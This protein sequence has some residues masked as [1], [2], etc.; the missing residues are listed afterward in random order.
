[1]N[2]GTIWV[3]HLIVLRLFCNSQV[4]YATS[5]QEVDVLAMAVVMSRLGL[6]LR[7]GGVYGSARILAKG[8]SV[9][10]L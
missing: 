6:T 4:S 1:M 5:F 9:N 2:D 8:Q 10:T 3:D 7:S